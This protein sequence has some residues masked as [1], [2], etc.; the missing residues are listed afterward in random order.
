MPGAGGASEGRAMWLTGT[1]QCGVLSAIALMGLAAC[2]A[3]GGGPAHGFDQGVTMTRAQA[4]EDIDFALKALADIH[5]DLYWRSDPA[6]IARRQQEVVAALPEKPT[7]L[8]LYIGLGELTSLFNDAHVAVTELPVHLRGSEGRSFAVSY[9]GTGGRF[10]A[11]LDPYA[12]GLR[13][14]DVPPRQVLLAPGDTI[15]SI[16][17]VPASE[18]LERLMALAPGSAETKRYEARMR[19]PVTLW[20][21]GIKAPFQV[22]LAASNTR[23]M[24]TVILDGWT[25][26]DG[27]PPGTLTQTEPIKYEV[28]TDGI[29]LIRFIDMTESPERFYD[30]LLEIFRRISKNPPKGLVIDIRRNPG[31]NSLLGAMLLS[32]VTEKPYRLFTERHW[33]VSRTCQ[34]WY[35]TESDRDP[36]HLKPYLAARPGQILDAQLKEKRPQ[37]STLA[38]KGPVAALIGPGTFSSAAILADAMSTYHL[39]TL[40]GRPTTEPANQYGEVC[41]APLPN[42]GIHVGGPSALVV[43][44]N[45]DAS[46]RGPV[47]PDVLI[48]SDPADP[49][50]DPTLDAARGW[51]RSRIAGP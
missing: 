6:D 17:G 41:E 27:T 19:L 22:A 13:V 16:N 15:S 50:E 3:G 2:S 39:A 4:V 48:D 29:G 28:L 18:I 38:Y 26:D 31:G 14:R 21:I 33:K 8:D 46:S 35:A 30:R 12:E 42:S 25:R 44:A 23:A 9:F 10:P 36:Q 20:E 11:S 32:F 51:I 45:G 5:P 34:E 24:R 7:K 43:R 37:M 1:S 47:V 49:K 40:F